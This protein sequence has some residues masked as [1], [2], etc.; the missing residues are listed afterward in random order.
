MMPVIKSLSCFVSGLLLV[1][2]CQVAVAQEQGELDQLLFT[3]KSCHGENLQGKYP[4]HVPALAGQLPSYLAMQLTQYRS[5]NRGAHLDDVL[6]QQMALM[7][8]TLGD[9][10]IQQLAN[11][12]SALEQ[13]SSAA[14]LCELEPAEFAVASETYRVCAACHGSNGEG[15]SELRS[16]NL[17]ILHPSYISRQLANYQLGYRSGST[18]AISMQAISSGLTKKD[19]NLL[20]DYLCVLSTESASIESAAGHGAQ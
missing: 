10:E 20:S 15:N 16:P 5:G 1:F 18:D 14:Q 2:A 4:N 8:A 6:G 11:Y 13:K 12:I 3:C 9:E 17:V 7:A 19:I